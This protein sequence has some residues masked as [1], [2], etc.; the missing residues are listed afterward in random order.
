VSRSST[1]IAVQ[2]AT[3]S[4]SFAAPDPAVPSGARLPLPPSECQV[5]LKARPNVLLEGSESVVAA[6]LLALK[7]LTQGPVQ[8]SRAPLC[9]PDSGVRTFVIHDVDGLHAEDQ[10]RL[11]QWLAERPAGLQVIATTSRPLFEMTADGSFLPELYYRLNVVRI[12]VPARG[13][14]LHS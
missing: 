11:S 2:H 1:F 3:R 10:T 12:A 13:G 4:S 7:P 14:E 6:T 9:L 5:L 8:S